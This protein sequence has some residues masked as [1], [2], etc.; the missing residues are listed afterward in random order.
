MQLQYETQNSSSCKG[1]LRLSCWTVNF[2]FRKWLTVIH[3]IFVMISMFVFWIQQ[4]L[5]LLKKHRKVMFV[6]LVWFKNCRPVA[7]Q[8]HLTSLRGVVGCVSEVCSVAPV[9]HPIV[10]SQCA[11]TH[12]SMRLHHPGVLWP[13]WD[14]RQPAETKGCYCSW[15]RY[16]ST[17]VITLHFCSSFLWATLSCRL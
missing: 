8:P 4:T 6:C 3:M 15:L 9:P 7:T 5:E 17:I 2:K 1:T 11:G 16:T 10:M 14:A 12:W 13:L